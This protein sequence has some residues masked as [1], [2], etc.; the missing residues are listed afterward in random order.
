MMS[1]LLNNWEVELAGI[2]LVGGSLKDIWLLLLAS[3]FDTFSYLLSNC[4][5]VRTDARE[6]LR[7][8]EGQES[9]CLIGNMMPRGLWSPGSA[10]AL[11]L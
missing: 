1:D 6:I 3:C 7:F 4:L 9:W 11:Q 10:F 8:A 2:G 5:S